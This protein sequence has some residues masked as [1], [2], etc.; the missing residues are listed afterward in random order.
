MPKSTST[1]PLIKKGTCSVPMVPVSPGASIMN[2]TCTDALALPVVPPPVG[3][4][5]AS[6]VF[7]HAA[8]E[9]LAQRTHP[10]SNSA[11]ASPHAFFYMSATSTHSS[12][13]ITR[14]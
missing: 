2:G 14:I 7:N 6:A 5:P 9:W 4:S 8:S 10:R 11:N 1:L 12:A 13:N 3:D